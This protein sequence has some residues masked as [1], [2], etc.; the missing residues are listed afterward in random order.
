MNNSTEPVQPNREPQKSPVCPGEEQIVQPSNPDTEINPR[1]P[2]NDT[3][4]DLDKSKINTYPDKR[5][6]ERH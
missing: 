1:N 6:P 3:E 4:V 5:P 2:G